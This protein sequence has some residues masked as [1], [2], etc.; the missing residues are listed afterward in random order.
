MAVV[1]LALLSLGVLERLGPE[2]QWR[3]E[4]GGRRMTMALSGGHLGCVNLRVPVGIT[5]TAVGGS[6]RWSLLARHRAGSDHGPPSREARALHLVLQKHV[7][8]WRE[9]HTGPGEKAG[10]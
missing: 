6:W 2:G 5:R 4:F 10:G 3:P 7:V 8:L 1:A 9:P